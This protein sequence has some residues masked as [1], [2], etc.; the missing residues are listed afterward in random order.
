MAINNPNYLTSSIKFRYL[1]AQ[2]FN[3]HNSLPTTIE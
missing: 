1:K 3:K 2:S